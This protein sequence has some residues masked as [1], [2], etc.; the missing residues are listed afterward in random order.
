MPASGFTSLL[1]FLV[2]IVLIPVALWLLKRT[3]MGAGAAHGTMRA[4]AALPLSQNQ[5]L[6]TVEVGQ[7]DQRKWLVLG[8][9]P[10]QITTLYTME[11]GADPTLSAGQPT[12]PFAH[13]LNRLRGDQGTAK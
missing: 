9:T 12:A 8:V 10:Q 4:I 6:I 2:V 13:L 3:P 11:P 5:R 1:G 7:G